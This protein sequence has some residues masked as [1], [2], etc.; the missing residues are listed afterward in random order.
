MYFRGFYL[1]VLGILM[2]CGLTAC[3]KVN[4]QPILTYK[5]T[6]VLDEA[7]ENS[8]I[9]ELTFAGDADGETEIVLGKAWADEQTPWTRFKDISLTSDGQRL[10]FNLD[11]G[12]LIVVHDANKP[13]KLTYH[14]NENDGRD[15]NGD[16]GFFYAP[17]LHDDIYHLIGWSS[18]AVPVV[19]ARNEAGQRAARVMLNWHLPESWKSAASFDTKAQTSIPFDDIFPAALTAGDF[20][21]TSRPL[22]DKQLNVIMSG[23]WPF[24]E[25]QFADKLSQILAALNENWND[26]PV[27]YHVSL[28]PL[29][30]I[31][32]GS[33][34][35][36]TGLNHAFAAA[37]T[38][39][40]ELDFLTMFLTHEMTHDWIPTRLGK[41]PNCKE[42]EDSNLDCAAEIY[43][44]SEGFT[45]F[46]ALSLLQQYDLISQEDFIK[47]TNEKLRDYYLSPARNVAN[48]KIQQDFWNDLDVERQPY[49]RGFLL[50]LNWNQDILKKSDGA[51]NMSSALRDLKDKAT[52][53]EISP[54]LTQDYLAAHFSQ[55][56]GR[57]VTADLKTYIIEGVTL[58]PANDAI[59]ACTTLEA[60]D[61]YIYSLGFNV[62]ASLGSGT[63]SGVEKGHNSYEAGL[64]D[65][66][67]FVQKVE[68]GGG[69]TTRPI[70]LEVKDNNKTLEVS[71][72]PIGEESTKIPQYK[73]INTKDCKVL[74]PNITD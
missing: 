34:F 70:V 20:N 65:G 13:L 31:P 17:I 5:L 59:G 30:P 29:P 41:F 71:Y 48:V 10:P 56:T 25:T 4:E 47:K 73:K 52:A 3:Q 66:M 11:T 49:L 43:W 6:P 50:A 2:S 38:E 39:N 1:G 62:E 36:G 22:G 27:D 12:R 58:A 33:S 45:E 8:L 42:E 53:F 26:S 67:T 68:G 9:V 61:I 21:I 28:L 19:Q 46:Y 37:G 40:I 74:V 32:N 14:L 60:A 51:D 64:R 54:E 69:D 15:P 16:S 57:D 7:S 44:F 55:W 72:L 24:S 23:A 18:L 63:F 35:T